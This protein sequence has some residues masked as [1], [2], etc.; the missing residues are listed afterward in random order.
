MPPS[1]SYLSTF[2]DRPPSTPA[3]VELLSSSSPTYPGWHPIPKSWPVPNLATG[4]DLP[5]K[6]PPWA[7]TS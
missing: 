4:L 2:P 1:D 3:Q 7:N 5:L 6:V